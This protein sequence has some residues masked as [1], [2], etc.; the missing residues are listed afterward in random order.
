MRSSPPY[1]TTIYVSGSG[2]K[3]PTSGSDRL[4]KVPRASQLVDTGR[5]CL[6]LNQFPIKVNDK[7][8]IYPIVHCH[9]DLRASW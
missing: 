1:L 4:P 8:L 7:R 9:V 5:K 6:V 3:A 2:K